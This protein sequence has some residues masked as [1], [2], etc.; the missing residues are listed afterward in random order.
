MRFYQTILLGTHQAPRIKVR[1]LRGVDLN[2]QMAMSTSRSA[3]PAL[4]LAKEVAAL[5]SEIVMAPTRDATVRRGEAARC[6]K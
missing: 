4:S 5:A 1:Q 2:S 3:W 6:S